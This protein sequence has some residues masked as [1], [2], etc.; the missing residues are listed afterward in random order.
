MNLDDLLHLSPKVEAQLASG[1][2]EQFR[3]RIY[4]HCRE[5]VK[6]VGRWLPTW[7]PG[8][9]PVLRMD[10]HTTTTA[11]DSAYLDLVRD[12]AFHEY[13]NGPAP[14]KVAAGVT[15]WLNRFRPL[16]LADEPKQ[17]NHKLLYVNPLW[18]LMVGSS[19]R[20]AYK[21]A[22]KETDVASTPSTA[23]S[24]GHRSEVLEILYC[25]QWRNPGYRQLTTLFKLATFLG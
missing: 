9:Q 7:L 22:G 19:V 18:A 20:A 17:R 11:I 3:R 6:E 2:A 12:E 1:D 5:G 13:K 24:E 14:E 4:G 10:I 21:F 25:L 23:L 15:A 8:E 16:S